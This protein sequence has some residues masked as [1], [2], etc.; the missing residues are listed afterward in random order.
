VRHA[1][2]RLPDP[3]SI[4]P[5][6]RLDDVCRSFPAAGGEREVLRG[7][8]MEVEAGE[9]V[10]IV[11]RS[12]SGKTTLLN[13]VAGLDSGYRG[14]VVLAGRDLRRVTD[15]ELSGLRNRTVGLVFQDYNLLE[16]L[17]VLENAFLPWLFARED[18][19][20]GARAAWERAEEVLVR[21]GLGGRGSS[22]PRELSGGQQ[23]RLALARALFNRPRILLCD[24]PTG[25]LDR[26]TAVEMVDLLQEVH[27]DDGVTVV[28][29]THDE[30]IAAAAG[31]VLHL[32][33][34]LLGDGP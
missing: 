18:A 29:A 31:R 23:Q 22:Y 1:A 14:T 12:G 8:A 25:N 11:G 9:L 28:A 16:H 10:A 5:A 27:R 7:V 30:A 6:I 26:D 34:G 15:R 3:V 4:D 24:E 19:R 21:V 32:R 33:D 13:I 20:V 17:S 2:P